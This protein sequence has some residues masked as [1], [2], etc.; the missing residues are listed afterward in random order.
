M[1]CLSLLS[2]ET[3]PIRKDPLAENVTSSL[4]NRWPV[5]NGAGG[6]L[7][8]AAEEP[9]AG[10]S[11]ERKGKLPGDVLPSFTGLCK[12]KPSRTMGGCILHS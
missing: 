7:G 10:P 9:T 11:V 12:Q 1:L 8:T 2:A 6:A 3:A 4:A 5:T